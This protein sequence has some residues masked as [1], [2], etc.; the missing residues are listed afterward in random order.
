M[1]AFTEDIATQT[2]VRITT[3]YH[4]EF[5][6]LVVALEEA[7]GVDE[8]AI[9]TD[10]DTITELRELFFTTTRLV[11]YIQEGKI[12]IRAQPTHLQSLII[13]E[14][15]VE[16]TTGFPDADPTVVE[17]TE[18]SIVEDTIK[19][20]DER[21]EEAEEVTFRKPGYSSLLD[22][23]RQQF[24]DSLVEDFEEALRKAKEPER[25]SLEIDPVFV[26][27][28]VGAY[29]EVSFYQL[30]RW[31]ED[32]GLASRAKFS[33]KKGE[34]EEEGIIDYENIPRPVGRPRQRLLVGEA[35]ADEESIEDIIA[36][37]IQDLSD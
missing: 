21:F 10:S 23:L 33:R 35:V 6:D 1:E 12:E 5:T 36:T 27:I 18:E 32:I 22:S 25:P 26:N 14:D 15:S 7:D 3:S 30:S 9:L 13:T 29:N 34:L 11:D 2:R 31:S 8:I 4:S 28:L 16:A 24:D 19:T 20:F 17:T 37:A